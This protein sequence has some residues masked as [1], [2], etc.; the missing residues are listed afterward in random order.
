M[1]SIVTHKSV[2]VSVGDAESVECE[3][4]AAYRLLGRITHTS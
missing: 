3:P 1:N 2:R 4:G